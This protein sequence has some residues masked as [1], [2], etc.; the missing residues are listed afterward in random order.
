MHSPNSIPGAHESHASHVSRMPW[1]PHAL[2]SCL[3]R[4]SLRAYQRYAGT[5]PA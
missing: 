4:S 1:Q 3:A 5:L 2:V